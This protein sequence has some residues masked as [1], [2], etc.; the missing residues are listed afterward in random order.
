MALAPALASR[1]ARVALA[2]ITREY[3]HKLD[4]VHRGPA[5]LHAPRALHP[6]FYGCYDWH[7]AVHSHWMLARLLRVCPDLPERAAVL[8]VFAA[9]F[10]AAPLAAELA[11]IEEPGRAGFERPYGWAWFM[12]LAA[13]VAALPH[14]EAAAWH[15]R[16]APIAAVFA[17]RL[18]DHLP[19]QTWPIRAGTHVNTAFALARAWDYAQASAD[20]ALA[21]AVRAAAL[22]FYEADRDGAANYEPSGNDFLSPCLVEADLMR[23]FHDPVAYAR[24]LARFLPGF[25]GGVAARLLEPVAVS[26]RADAQGVHLDGLNLSRAWCLAGIAAHLPAGDTRVRALRAS[27]RAHLEAGL[28]H[29]DSGDFLAEHWLGSFAVAALTL[30]PDA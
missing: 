12:Q 19:R 28:A 18:V 11:Y 9:H 29:V 8:E 27:A 7:S 10:A 30:P 14:P 13:E 24:W 1:L 21:D 23:R 15:A 17:R 16:L 6:A 25:L 5:D 20:I 22:R 26:D 2:G 4:H 3:P